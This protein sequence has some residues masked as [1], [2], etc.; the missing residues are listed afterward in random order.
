MNLI[1][2][3]VG[4]SRFA[5]K[6]FLFGAVAAAVAA[7]VWQLPTTG[8]A[9]VVLTEVDPTGS[10]TT[11]NSYN[12]DW[13][14]LTNTGAAA[15]DITGWKMDDNSNA[16]A[17]A[18]AIRGVTSI[19]PGQSVVFV[20]SNTSGTNDATIEA[21]FKSFWFGSNVPAGFTIGAYGGS[22][23]GLSSSAGDAVNI[24]DAGGNRV[25]G[26]AFGAIVD[27]TSLDNYAGAGSTTLPLP[28]ISTLSVVGVN[29][30][31][32]SFGAGGAQPVHEIGSPG[33]VPEPSS[34]VLAALGLLG[35]GF[36]GRRR[37]ARTSR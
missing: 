23:V 29:N 22:G 15:V 33:A 7:L 27:G 10:A 13:F 6:Q 2:K 12:A 16:F 18:V 9:A 31:F 17:T 35:A 14:E 19:A 5:R 24:F 28:T 1:S 8:E 36:V 4:Q 20:E 30:A 11:I 32:A 3:F 25:T 34:I 21:A 26:V 37:R